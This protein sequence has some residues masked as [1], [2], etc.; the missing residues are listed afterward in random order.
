[1]GC[2]GRSQRGGRT[3]R[4]EPRESFLSG[5]LYH[6]LQ[7]SEQLSQENALR[8][9]SPMQVRLLVQFKDGTTREWKSMTQMDQV[10]EALRKVIGPL[11]TQ[12]CTCGSLHIPDLGSVAVDVAAVPRP[13]AA[14]EQPQTQLPLSFFWIDIVGTPEPHDF[15]VLFSLLKT[16]TCTERRWRDEAAAAL[17]APAE[18][19]LVST[20][21]C[22]SDGE[23]EL[24]LGSDEGTQEREPDELQVFAEKKY[25]QMLLA[26]IL[27]SRPSGADSFGTDSD[28]SAVAQ[29]PDRLHANLFDVD[30]ESGLG[31]VRLLCFADGIVSWRPTAEVEGWEYVSQNVAQHLAELSPAK[32][33]LTTSWLLHIILDELCEAF[34]P[35]PTLVFNEVDAID[36]M[37]PLVRQKESEQADVLRRA[38]RLQRCLSVHR[39]LLLSKVNLLGQLGRPVMRTLFAFITADAW[40]AGGVVHQPNFVVANAA[41]GSAPV[42]ELQRLAH[43]AILRR[44]LHLLRQ[45]DG[46]R[47]ILGNTTIIYTSAVTMLNNNI[48][49]HAD[50]RMVVLHYVTLVFLPLTVVASQWGM[51]CYVPWKELDST[52]PFWSIVGISAAYAALHLFY[53]IYCMCIGRADKLV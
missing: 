24:F 50:Y 46:A 13:G 10:V 4:S 44:I 3:G 53:P 7:S 9:G 12:H 16:H 38:L 42:A 11:N 34:L 22:P 51:N 49:T 6:A 47:T 25:V 48:S 18:G 20:T 30:D 17:A 52:T 27:A 41:E 35:D 29:Q 21:D 31:W 33:M 45:L 2:S 40:N 36:S 43:T 8:G 32:R 14:W 15:T 28:G 23:P 1:M 39:R 26:V 19:Y 37:M 5:N